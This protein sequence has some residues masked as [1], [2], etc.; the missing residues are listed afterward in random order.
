MFTEVGLGG[1]DPFANPLEEALGNLVLK[2]VVVARSIMITERSAAKSAKSL[3][4]LC[5]TGV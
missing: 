1:N 2:L 3:R 4:Q 5:H